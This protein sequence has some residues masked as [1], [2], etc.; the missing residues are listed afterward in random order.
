MIFI[1]IKR[2]AK[3]FRPLQTIKVGPQRGLV[4]VNSVYVGNRMRPNKSRHLSGGLQHGSLERGR[5]KN[6]VCLKTH[7][8]TS[9]HPTLSVVSNV[10]HHGGRVQEDKCGHVVD[11]GLGMLSMP[12]VKPIVPE[13]DVPMMIDVEITQ[14][15]RHE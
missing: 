14:E 6:V 7:A 1:A 11:E 13:H 3:R 10:V 8:T 4:G 15:V 5:M 2:K 12:L 9:C